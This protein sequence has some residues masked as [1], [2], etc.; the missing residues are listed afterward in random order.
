[1]NGRKYKHER[2]TH[3]WL[4]RRTWKEKVSKEDRSETKERLTCGQNDELSKPNL[5]RDKGYKT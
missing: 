4:K 3:V 1:M 2:V 5:K